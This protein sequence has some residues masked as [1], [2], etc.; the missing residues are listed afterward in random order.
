MIAV[1]VGSIAPLE[2]VVLVFNVGLVEEIP[3]SRPTGGH[4]R[5]TLPVTRSG[6]YPMG[7]LDGY[8]V[9]PM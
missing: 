2:K 8:G 5:K 4:H 6:E 1:R 7:A 9:R 3:L